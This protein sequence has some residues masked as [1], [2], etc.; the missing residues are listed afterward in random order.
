MDVTRTRFVGRKYRQEARN[1]TLY[2]IHSTL[3]LQTPIRTDCKL[4]RLPTV[5]KGYRVIPVCENRPLVVSEYH[6]SALVGWVVV[7]FASSGNLDHHPQPIQRG[8]FIALSSQTADARRY[9]PVTHR[10]P[11]QTGAITQPRRRH[12]GLGDKR[13][14]AEAA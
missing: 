4:N 13:G 10:N 3:V 1:F 14:T 6:G 2:S 7:H 8:F 11:Q 5:K 9:P 12:T